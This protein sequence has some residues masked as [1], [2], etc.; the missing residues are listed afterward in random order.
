MDGWKCYN[1]DNEKSATRETV[2]WHEKTTRR[3]H[4][5]PFEELLRMQGPR[6]GGDEINISLWLDSRPTA[7]ASLQG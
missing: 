7:T 5:K 2:H 3:S 1:P 6:H 4:C